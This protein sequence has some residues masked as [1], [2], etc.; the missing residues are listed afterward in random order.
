MSCPSGQA[1]Q[2]H[3][4]LIPRG[5]Q[6]IGSTLLPLGC[7]SL[8]F[9]N[10]GGNRSRQGEGDEWTSRDVCGARPS[11]PLPSGAALCRFLAMPRELGQSFCPE[12]HSFDTLATLEAGRPSSLPA[13]RVASPIPR[14]PHRELCPCAPAPAG[15]SSVE[16]YVAP[17][18]LHSTTAIQGTI[19]V[20]RAVPRTSETSSKQ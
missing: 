3:P 4:V 20:S 17:S 15:A 18:P 19:T 5:Q 14:C 13:F 12:S 16:Q 8:K 6:H 9:S 7:Q 2:R 1:K 11:A 10:L